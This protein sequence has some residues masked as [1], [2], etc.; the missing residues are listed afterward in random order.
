VAELLTGLAPVLGASP[1]ILLLGSMPGAASLLEQ[2][3]Y[4]H[5][6]NLFWPFMQQLFAITVELDY[7]KRCQL[8]TEQG[9]A[10]WDVIARCE[11]AGSLDSAIKKSSVICN[12]IPQLLAAEP[13]IKKIC[14]NGA[15]AAEEFKR[16]LLPQLRHRPDL[17]YIQ[18]P[19]SSPAHASQ[20]K[21]Q[22][23]ALWAS[24]LREH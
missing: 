3:Y 24:A 6:R 12:A 21:E 1:R 2:R 18:L 10:L 13:Q 15:K 11:R 9:I 22:K 5:P 19:S 14:F 20:S 4:A 16:H 7:T 8:L 17:R 23:L